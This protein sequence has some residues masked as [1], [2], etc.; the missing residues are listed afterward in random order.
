M[1]MNPRLLRPT[2]SGLDP[3]ALAWRAAV[4]AAGSSVDG[5]VVTA[6]SR[7][8]KGCKAD[9]IWDAMKSVV[10]LAGADTLAG[11]LAPLKGTAPTSYNFVSGDYSKTS[12]LVGNGST[13]YL[14]SNR[15]GNADP[16]DDNHMAMWVSD[17]GTT[18]TQS[19]V[20][21]VATV[22]TY[23][24]KNS[25]GGTGYLNNNASTGVTAQYPGNGSLLGM[26]RSQA[27]EFLVRLNG[28][29]VTRVSASTGVNSID[30]F[31]F[32]RNSNG[33]ALGHVDS[34][35]AFYSIG[36]SLDLALLDARVS[37]L[38]TDLGV[39]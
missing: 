2:A 18:A 29:I 25:S 34:T 6:V 15:A 13:K 38:M 14:D 4:I 36:E 23:F 24:F 20:G 16:Q 21:S 8:V 1:P 35:L 26:S 7:F 10:L 12:G 39:S 22:E 19:F 37:A 31:V 11:A 17:V 32:A 27:S 9:G 30:A 5:G 3:D 28:A 33:T